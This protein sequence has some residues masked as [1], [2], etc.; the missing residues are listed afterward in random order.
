MLR[1]E[2]ELISLAAS[3]R[4]LDVFK[5]W[6]ETIWEALAEEPSVNQYLTYIYV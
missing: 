5:R 4:E 3:E 2:N 6:L 1:R